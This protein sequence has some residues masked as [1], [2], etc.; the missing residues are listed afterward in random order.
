MSPLTPD[1]FLAGLA[2]LTL[3]SQ[4]AEEQG[5]AELV[6]SP[7][8]RATAALQ[9]SGGIGTIWTYGLFPDRGGCEATLPS[10]DRRP[11]ESAR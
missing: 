5:G 7:P 3:L 6:R 9:L 4:A 8:L 11:A 2:V 1:R 10:A